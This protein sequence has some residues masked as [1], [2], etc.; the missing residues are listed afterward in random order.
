MHARSL[1]P[2]IYYASQPFCRR[3][4]KRTATT[5][6]AD[7]RGLRAGKLAIRG[8]TNTTADLPHPAPH[9]TERTTPED[10]SLTAITPVPTEILSRIVR[11]DVRSTALLFYRGGTGGDVDCERS[12]F[13]VDS[14]QGKTSSFITFFLIAMGLVFGVVFL[15]WK[16]TEHRDETIRV[17]FDFGQPQKNRVAV[18]FFHNLSGNPEDEYW[19]EGLT[20]DII[21]RLAA[22][23]GLNVKS[24][25]D[26]LRFKDRPVTVKEIGKALDVDAVLEGSVRKMGD[27]LLVSAQLIDVAT[28][29]HIWAQRYERRISIED[30]FG[31]QNELATK[32][33]EAAHLKL[34][35]SEKMTLIRKPTVS[36]EAYEFYLKGK[37]YHLQMTIEGNWIA[38]EM[39]QKAIDLDPGFA[40]AYA[41]LGD[42]YVNHFH[43]VEP[44]D[45]FWL[46]QAEEQIRKALAI[47]SDLPEAHKALGHCFA[48]LGEDDKAAAAYEKALAL[49][50]DFPE[51]EIGLAEVYVTMGRHDEAIARLKQALQRHPELPYLYYVI[52][53]AYSAK[54][55]KDEALSW[56]NKAVERGYRNAGYMKK[57]PMLRPLL[58]DPQFIRLMK[59]IQKSRRE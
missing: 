54:K 5:R 17:T 18:L 11:E 40:L 59:E 56:I 58:K 16:M 23:E 2:Y 46:N 38:I 42:A 28:G 33:A 49:K 31:L 6:G 24:M 44:A 3:N 39:F 34:T 19:C 43:M 13:I 9:V 27:T 21:M 36:V 41:D 14:V 32:I 8:F 51:A 7:I 15:I 35:Q 37:Y 45:P 55:E 30:I 4:T 26:V 53:A 10:T 12:K 50:R 52:G 48:Q 25:T 57:D 29:L 1:G 20:D 22:I 47:D